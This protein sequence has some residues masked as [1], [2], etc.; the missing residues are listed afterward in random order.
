[1]G[2]ENVVASIM[3]TIAII[4]AAYTFLSGTGLLAE[5][6]IESYRS[7]AEKALERLSTSIE[8]LNVSY[9]GGEIVSEV[10]N[11]GSVKFADFVGFDA[12][13]YG[14]TDS[15]ERIADYVSGNFTIVDEIT[16]P[17]IFDPHET[18]I[19]RTS[20]SLQNGTYVLQI[21]TSN[22]VCDSFEFEVR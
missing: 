4:V 12:F 9:S 19:F 15:G 5:T 1:M 2:F 14:V 16:N 7:S 21:C 3:L 20:Y 6:T 22:A 8:I 10:K 18:A 13:I 11:V 17:G